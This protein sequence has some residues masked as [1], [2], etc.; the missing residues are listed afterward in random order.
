MVGSFSSI[1]GN[2]QNTA[3]P[4][5]SASFEPIYV[6]VPQGL[7]VNIGSINLGEATQLGNGSIVLHIQAEE[8]LEEI[9][10]T[11]FINEKEPEVLASLKNASGD[12][13]L[14]FERNLLSEFTKLHVSIK[15]NSNHNLKDR[16]QV[17]PISIS[18]NS[19]N[20]PIHS[21][22]QLP[23]LRIAKP[24]RTF[25]DDGINSFRIPGLVTS[26][27]G[28]L[29]AVYDIRR[30]SSRDLQGDIDVGL[31]RS[32]DGGITW[33]PMQVIMDMGEWGEL[34]E[35]ENGIG[36]PAILVD[37]Q[38]GHIWVA[39]L[40]MHGKPGKMAWNS[41][42]PGMTPKETG[43]FVLVKSEDDGAT[44]S[45]P[46]IITEQIKNPEWNLFFNGPGKGITLQDGT[47]VFPAQYKD[48]DQMPHSTIVFSKDKG[49]SWQVGTGAKSNTTEAQVVELQD[50][51][52]ML[53]MR[54][55][56]GG[57]RSVAVTKDLGA[58]W[59]EHSTSRSALPEP[60][61]MAS[62]IENRFDPSMLLF[63]NPAT[64]KERKN[65][66]IK[67]SL[68][69]G[70][71]WPSQH[72]LLLDEGTGWGYSCLTMINKEEVGILYESSVAN[73]TFQIIPLKDILGAQ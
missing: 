59:T 33:E 26:T 39:A 36:D 31:N 19:K 65:I 70:N 17:R 23:A 48:K 67:A 11:A 4:K 32:F 2:C 21:K 41:S 24:L 28:T 20:Y 25:G 9:Q 10:L 57:S 42:G 22:R 34:P 44:W 64:E 71:S 55:N 58:S 12:V 7:L 14:D 37:H 54:D 47:L 63:S 1:P 52:L 40:W 51:S 30:N 27:K 6:P 50:G 66:T 72:H 38:T 49:K 18:S 68:D 53:N 62:L 29:L 61:C 5:F 16:I 46:M 60:V 8:P 43:Q 13:T 45:E 56:R 73:M 3:D 69:N 15:V 35:S